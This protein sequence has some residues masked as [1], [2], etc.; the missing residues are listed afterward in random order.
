MELLVGILQFIGWLFT[1][2]CVIF[3]SWFVILFFKNLKVE[4]NHT[5]NKDSNVDPMSLGQ[6]MIVYIEQSENNML[7]MYDLMSDFFI[8]QGKDEQELWE[9]AQLRCPDQNLVLTER[10]GSKARVVTVKAKN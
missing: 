4:V 6:N 10:D 8:A 1:I 3:S 2:I 7:H 5:K 9:R